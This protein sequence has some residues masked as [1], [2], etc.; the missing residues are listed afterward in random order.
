M[1]IKR[2]IPIQIHLQEK[3]ILLLGPRRTGK[4]SLI[5]HEVK[6]DCLIN[7]LHAED[8]QKLSYNPSILKDYIK[9]KDRVIAID[10]VQRLPSLMDE[11]HS[12]IE[13]DKRLRFVLSGSSVKNIKK[14]HTSLMAGRARQML[15]LPFSYIEVKNHHFDLIKFLAYGGLPPVYLSKK[16][17]E[18]LKD[19]TGEYLRE[20]IMAS[21]FVRKIEN[22]SR[23]LS[24]AAKTNGQI[25]NFESLARDAFIPARTIRDYY[26]LLEETMIGYILPPYKKK[27]N[28]KEV[29]TSKFY[30]FDL[31]VC[32]SIVKRDVL[33]EKSPAFGELFEHFIFLELKN[34]QKQ[35]RVDWELSF[36]RTHTGYEVDFVLGEGHVI[37]EV[38]SS[39]KISLADLKGIE[40]FSEDQKVKRKIVVCR[41]EKVRQV[42]DVEI[43]PWEKF[44][45]MLWA[46]DI[47]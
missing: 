34:Y 17:W 37:I 36:W 18:E 24:F 29:S 30:F 35:S 44:L 2:R 7:L 33:H 26:D 28:R 32:N 20:E 10:E 3:S 27:T 19:Y 39:K 40:K 11:I 21:A 23:F 46:G 13:K 15:L 14:T 42:D 16:P 8:F 41:E 6:P 38:K 4:S 22:Y 43:L 1:Y 5:E 31:G 45:E 25:L 12:L 9:S 47:A